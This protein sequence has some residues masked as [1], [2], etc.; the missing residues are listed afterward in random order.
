MELLNIE[1]RKSIWT[2]YLY[3]NSK[4]FS[5]R[6]KARNSKELQKFSIL[7]TS[8]FQ[9]FRTANLSF[10]FSLDEVDSAEYDA[11]YDLYEDYR[12]AD[13]RGRRRSTVDRRCVQIF[14]AWLNPFKETISMVTLLVGSRSFSILKTMIILNT[15]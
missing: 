6:W 3:L 1:S 14:K 5:W 15:N 4:A 7:G 12:K 10:L 2:P 11:L 9:L 8:K 13:F